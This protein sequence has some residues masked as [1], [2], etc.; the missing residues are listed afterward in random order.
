MAKEAEA[1]EWGKQQQKLEAAGK[2]FA[3]T[4]ERKAEI[5]KDQDA[6]AEQAKK[7]RKADPAMAEAAKF[8]HPMNRVQ[9]P[10]SS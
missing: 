7:D 1:V 3:V 4:A 2:L 8:Y 10:Y 9:L 6:R 5:K